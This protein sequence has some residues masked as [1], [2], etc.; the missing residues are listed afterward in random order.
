LAKA[1]NHARMYGLTDRKGTVAAGAD[2][3]LAIWDAKR[4]VTL[5]AGM[6]HDNVGYTPYEGR[7]VKGWPV[8]V[9]SRGRVVIEGGALHA[10]RGSA[11][12]FRAECQGQ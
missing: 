12:S 7:V 3:D 2:A 8:T 6:M 4:N 11:S 10:A 5:S 1:T 9:V